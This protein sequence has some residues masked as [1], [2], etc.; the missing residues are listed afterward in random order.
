MAQEITSKKPLAKGEI[1]PNDPVTVY[2]TEKAQFMKPGQE[3]EVH[4]ALAEK[5]IAS[6]KATKEAKSKK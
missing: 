6:G 5:L 3:W 4:S 2:A 1:K